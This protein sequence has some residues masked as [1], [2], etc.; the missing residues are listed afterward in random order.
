MNPNAA[1]ATPGPR[2][3]LADMASLARLLVRPLLAPDAADDALHAGLRAALQAGFGAVCVRPSDV[4]TAVRLCQDSG[5]AVGSVVG[6]PHG[7]ATT[8]SKLYEA[9]DLL[10]RGAREIEMVINLGKLRSRQFQYVE[11]EILQ[12]AQACHESQAIL[13]VTLENSVLTEDLKVIACKIAKRAEADVV[14]TA[15][16][17]A[18]VSPNWEQDLLLLQRVL[19]DV[20]VIEAGEG[21]DNLDA[22]LRAYELGAGRIATPQAETVL[23][24]WAAR[25][26]PP[27]VS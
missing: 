9:R 14:K 19:K 22:V 1:A 21:A 4:D 3:P 27:P 7:G 25:L 11:T 12:L 18:R 26:A 17:F 6:F 2:P 24:A 5:V 10:R 20:C 23:A 15:T 8:A 16:G 13:K